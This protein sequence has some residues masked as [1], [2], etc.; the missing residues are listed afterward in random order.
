MVV[1]SHIRHLQ[2][3][4]FM[5][6]HAH[7]HHHNHHHHH[8]HPWVMR[9]ASEATLTSIT[10]P[11]F[12]WWKPRLKQKKACLSLSSADIGRFVSQSTYNETSSF[13]MF[14]PLIIKNYNSW[15]LIILVYQWISMDSQWM[16]NQ[17][18]ISLSW[19]IHRL[20]RTSWCSAIFPWKQGEK[21]SHPDLP[22]GTRTER[23]GKRCW[24]V[25]SWDSD[26]SPEVTSMKHADFSTS[27]LIGVRNS[28]CFWAT[29]VERKRQY[30]TLNPTLID[31][32]KIYWLRSNEQTLRSI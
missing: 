28:L 2:D 17:W 30:E 1:A 16:Y 24:Q 22:S 13:I 14:Y 7:H 32:W 31:V 9:L 4:L 8:R 25:A 15:L 12:R 27:D 18:I 29:M 26:G 6:S 21:S 19:F 23:R 10:M 5:I 11:T 20:S 3:D